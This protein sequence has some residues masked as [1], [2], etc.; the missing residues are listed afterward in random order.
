[1]QWLATPAT[2]WDAFCVAAY[3]VI[4]LAMPFLLSFAIAV[5]SDA[6]SSGWERGS[7]LEEV[8][9]SPSPTLEDAV[10]GG[11]LGSAILDE[12]LQHLTGRGL[13]PHHAR[14]RC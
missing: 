8:D 12:S 10:F 7:T 4:P 13:P 6:S 3:I 5:S 1:M 14:H 11:D 2:A 9:A